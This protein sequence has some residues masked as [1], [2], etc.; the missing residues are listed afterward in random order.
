MSLY[1]CGTVTS[2]TEMKKPL[3]S[4]LVDVGGDDALTIVTNAQN[5]RESS[6]VVVACVG[7]VVPK[8]AEEGDDG[9]TTVG[10]RAV[11]GVMSEGMLCDSKMLS[12]SGGGEG[13][14]VQVP[15]TFPPGS[16][17][18]PSRPRMGGGP[19]AAAVEPLPPGQEAEPLFEKKMTKEEKKAA[20]K[21][22]RE[23]KKKAKADA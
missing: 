23:A 1:L 16:P 13:V 4:V 15:D 22:K 14:A 10:R 18:P 20:A 8:G 12:W 9:A 11:G 21:A 7:A 2:L 19:T 5:V 17:P 6:R 3:R